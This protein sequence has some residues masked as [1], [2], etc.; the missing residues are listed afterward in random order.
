MSHYFCIL[1]HIRITMNLNTKK[2]TSLNEF[3]QPLKLEQFTRH[4]K[5]NNLH[6]DFQQQK[7]KRSQEKNKQWIFKRSKQIYSMTNKRVLQ[8]ALQLDFGVV[9][10]ICNSWYFY[11]VNV[12]EQVATIAP[13]ATCCI[14][15]HIHIQNTCNFVPLCCN[16]TITP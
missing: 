10:T 16:L 13:N 7:I 1:P 2:H 12:I 11:G 4:N 6:L 8:L 9:L 14:W 15:H 3:L 5:R